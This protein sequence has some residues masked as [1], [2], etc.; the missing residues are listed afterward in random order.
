M[1]PSPEGVAES[2]RVFRVKKN[3]G[4]EA[5]NQDEKCRFQFQVKSDTQLE[6]ILVRA[7]RKEGATRKI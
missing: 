2:G 1:T 6:T 5:N 3:K 4:K 7:L